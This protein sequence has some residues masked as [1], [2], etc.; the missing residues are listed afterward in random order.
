MKDT[1]IVQGTAWNRRAK[2]SWGLTIGYAVMPIFKRDNMSLRPM[3]HG[4]TKQAT[5]LRFGVLSMRLK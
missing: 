5:N 3:I 4:I 1:R 2:N